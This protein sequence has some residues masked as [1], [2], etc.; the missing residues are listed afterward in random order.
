M[1]IPKMLTWNDRFALID[2]FNPTDNNIVVLFGI[3]SNELTAARNMRQVGI[4]LPT[5]HLDYESYAS[6]FS[7]NNKQEKQIMTTTQTA[8]NEPPQTATKKVLKRGRKG[9][10]IATAF[11]SVPNTPVNA[12][13]FA[14]KY[15]VSMAVLRQSK[16][17]DTAGL[18]GAIK[19]K[20]DKTTGVLMIWRESES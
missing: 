17:F 13:A 18:P 2:E 1:S 11:A 15:K 3:T 16:R 6:A 9:N 14:T 19:V 12:E 10:N 20:K 5:K 4:F 7:S 8:E